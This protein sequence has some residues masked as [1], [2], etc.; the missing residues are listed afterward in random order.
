MLIKLIRG[1]YEFQQNISDEIDAIYTQLSIEGQH[2]DVFLLTCVD[3]RVMPELLTKA[4][5]GELFTH[6]NAGNMMPAYNRI[7]KT[8]PA[9]VPS[10]IADLLYALE[11]NVKNIIICGHSDCGAMKILQNPHP[12]LTLTNHWVYAQACDPKAAEVKLIR[13]ETDTD[14]SFLTKK[15]I[16]T[17][18]RKLETYH[19]VR[20][21]KKAG[22]L[23]LHAWYFD[24]ESK[25]VF[26]YEQSCMKFVDLKTALD[27][28][29][30]AR[31]ENI[32]KNVIKEYLHTKLALPNDASEYKNRVKLLNSL[33]NVLT[34]IW[35][36]IKP[37]IAEKL[38]Q[39]LAGIYNSPNAKKFK[40]LVESSCSV[41]LTAK[42]KKALLKDLQ[43]TRGYYEYHHTMHKGLFVHPN[44]VATNEEHFS[45]KK[46]RMG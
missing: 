5:P 24:I 39:E 41:H 31:Q 12:K 7:Y 11:L 9:L 23:A 20:E 3:S 43:T 4:Q 42:D 30:I 35:E 22:A 2:P 10:E 38:W 44:P 26:I 27:Y 8:N 19:E 37:T 25:K 14:L 32:V 34:P 18:L 16:L 21:R 29:I 36:E 45:R 6:R 40:Q 13:E 33:Q 1:I 46:L 15:N 17:Q 28:A